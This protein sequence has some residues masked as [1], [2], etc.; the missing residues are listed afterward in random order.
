MLG[1]NVTIK[2][3]PLLDVHSHE[4]QASHGATIDRINDAK[5]FYLM[6]K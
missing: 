5:L 1:N 4:V 3:A 2:N 6:A